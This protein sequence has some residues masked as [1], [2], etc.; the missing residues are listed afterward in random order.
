MKSKTTTLAALC[1]VIL[2]F[3]GCASYSLPPIAADQIEYHRTDP[4]GGTLVKATG[5]KITDQTITA[6][7]AS[8][9]THY[10]SFSVTVE[11]KGYKRKIKISGP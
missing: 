9:V 7:T 6:E 10:P 2:F 1:I 3:T 4:F 5:V 8:W 11:V